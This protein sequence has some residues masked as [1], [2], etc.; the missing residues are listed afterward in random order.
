MASRDPARPN[1][2]VI[3]ADDQGPWAMGCAGNPEIITPNLDRLAAEGT[4]FENFFCTSPVC[5]PARASL[6]TGRMPSAHGVHDALWAGEVRDPIEF[7]EGQTAYTDVLAAAGYSCGLSGKWHLGAAT[8]PQLS[9]TEWNAWEGWGRGMYWDP[10]MNRGGRREQVPG[11][12]TDVFTDGALGFLDGWA[13]DDRPFL[14]QLCHVAP[15]APWVGIH[16][17]EWLALYDDCPFDSVPREPAHPWT[18]PRSTDWEPYVEARDDPR[19][20]LQG[21]FAAVTAMDAAIGR[22]LDRLD[23]LGLA[24]STLVLFLSDNGFSCGHNGIWGK[25]NGTLPQNLYDNSVKVPAIARQPGRVAAGQVRS[26]LVSAYDVRPTLLAWA[27]V[28]DSDSSGD[29]GL[30]P[31]RDFGPLLR[32]EPGGHEAVVVFDEYGPARM[33][34]T[35]EWKYVHRYPLGPHELY[36]LAEDPEERHNLVDDPARHGVA[37]DLRATLADWF[38]RY[39]DPRL[40]GTKEAV[41]GQGQIDLVGPRGGGRPAFNP[42]PTPAGE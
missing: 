41:T 11:Y 35:R 3:V 27:G 42:E 16:P 14:L 22:V 9:F 37:A 6:L 29:A 1:I 36:D 32:G 25:G 20:T 31:G 13:A 26:E 18:R 23:G 24:E 33:V 17:S 21:W 19:P 28:A 40:D 30:R 8:K 38:V 7:L 15:H 34:R 4:R 5:S 12:T 39:T 2:V 10:A